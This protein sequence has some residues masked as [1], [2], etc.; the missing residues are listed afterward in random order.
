MVVKGKFVRLLPFL[1]ITL[2]LSEVRA[3]EELRIVHKAAFDQTPI[4]LSLVDTLCLMVSNN[5]IALNKGQQEQ[6]SRAMDSIRK[7]ASDTQRACTDVESAATLL[8]LNKQLLDYLQEAINARLINLAPFTTVHRSVAVESI[9]D[10]ALE[11][12]EIQAGIADLEI[13]INDLGMTYTQKAGRWLTT[14]NE[15]YGIG[16]KTKTASVILFTTLLARYLFQTTQPPE[17]QEPEQ[18]WWKQFWNTEWP[19]DKIIGKRPE[20]ETRPTGNGLAFE[21]HLRPGTGTGIFGNIERGYK[22]ILILLSAPMLVQGGFERLVESINNMRAFH[23]NPTSFFKLGELFKA[24]KEQISALDELFLTNAID[25]DEPSITFDDIAGL[26]KQKKELQPLIDYLMNPDLFEKTGSVIEKGYLLYGPTRTG[27]T[28]IAEALAGEL[29]LKCKKKLPLIKV[30]GNQLQWVGIKKMLDLVN[31]YAPCILFIDELDVLNLQR[32]V[33]SGS[34]L[35][36]EFLTGMN[37]NDPKKQVIFLAATNRIDHIDHALLQPGRFGKIITFENPCIADRKDYFE[38][39]FTKK[40]LTSKSISCD[41]LARETEGCSFGDLNSI[42]NH[43]LT[44]ATQKSE[45]V[46]YTHFDQAIDVCKRHMSYDLSLINEDEQSTVAAYIAGKALAHVIIPGGKPLAKATIYPIRYT[47]PE[48]SI[49]AHQTIG[50]TKKI[51]QYGHVF[52]LEKI[53]VSGFESREQKIHA[54]KAIMAGTY[55]E[56][57]IHERHTVS[58]REDEY[59]QVH[60]LTEELVLQGV[61]KDKLSRTEADKKLDEVVACLRT[62]ETEVE[63]CML[64]HKDELIRVHKALLKNKILTAHEIETLLFR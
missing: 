43:A 18:N 13:E 8:N 59:A 27:K 49:W 39:Q 2:G 53:P 20:I 46:S 12:D 58:Y 23:R 24:E 40:Y 63:R 48:E 30:K 33:P 14:K 22:D 10:L 11:A 44:L 41:Q 4:L 45:R 3:Q 26:E 52:T 21:H 60:A 15:H 34:S 6:F 55:A 47:I 5:V 16:S 38:K 42:M 57:I 36:I 32:N 25:M 64:A 9:Q 19:V 29:S 31:K 56:K 7:C 37:T 54:I 28:Y 61:S 50:E 17:H 62:Y 51:T 1:F 35:L